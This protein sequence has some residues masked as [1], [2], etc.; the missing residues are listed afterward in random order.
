MDRA[1]VLDVWP[2]RIRRDANASQRRLQ[3]A[4]EY[5]AQKE[6]RERQAAAAAVAT[7]VGAATTAAQ[8]PSSSSAASATAS[9]TSPTSPTSSSQAGAQG[10]SVRFLPM[11]GPEMTEAQRLAVAM[12]EKELSAVEAETAEALAALARRNDELRE[13]QAELRRFARRANAAR[14]AARYRR[15]PPESLPPPPPPLFTSS[16]RIAARQLARRNAASEAEAAQALAE[17]AAAVAARRAREEARA[18]QAEVS[19]P[20]TEGS[21]HPCL[22]VSCVS[23]LCLSIR[24]MRAIACAP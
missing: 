10:T 23:S 1:G 4:R 12:V 6:D 20:S 11:C 19:V 2:Y 8:S 24:F 18:A 17:T 21:R 3:A 7:R 22:S 5:V 13:A 14:N 9:S 15:P 16:A